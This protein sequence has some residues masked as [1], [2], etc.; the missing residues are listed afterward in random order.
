MNVKRILFLDDASHCH[1]HFEDAIKSLGE[2]ELVSFYNGLELLPYYERTFQE[3][4]FD[5]IFLDLTMAYID[6]LSTAEKILA[7]NPKA[8]ITIMGGLQYPEYV[9][10]GIQMGV[11]WWMR[12]PIEKENIER[13]FSKMDEE[14]HE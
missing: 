6:G 5:Y 11:K 1:K 9:V 10:K 3:H 4:P 8:K 14:T 13:A 12:K 7:M 2:Y